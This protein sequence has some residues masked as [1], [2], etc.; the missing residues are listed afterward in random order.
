MV[1]SSSIFLFL[2]LP[3]VLTGYFCLKDNYKNIWL[4]LISLFFYSWG[5]PEY[6]F[7]M[8]LTICLNYTLVLLMVELNKSVYKRFVL[9]MAIISNLFILGYFKYVDFLINI[10][11]DIFVN[12]FSLQQ[13]ALPIGISFFIFQSLSYVID[14]Y[15]GEVK[16][17]KNILYLGLYIA[18]FPQL[19]AGPIVRYK[20]IE[21]EIINR[22]VTI[23][24][25]ATGARQ[26]M[27]GFSKKLLIADSLAPFVNEIFSIDGGSCLVAWLGAVAYTLQIFFDFSGYSDM[28]IGLGRM[29]GFTFPVN[30]YYPYISTS[31][32][33]FWRRWHMSLSSWF[34]DYVYIPL[35]GN[36]NG[37]LRTYINLWI[38][39]FLTGLWHGASWNFVVWGLYHGGFL[40]I[41]RLGADKILEKLPAIFR[42]VYLVV[43]VIIGWVFFN[44]QDLHHAVNYIKTMFNLTGQEY[45]DYIIYMDKQYMTC[46]IAG[47]VFSMPVVEWIRNNSLAHCKVFLLFNDIAVLGM[48]VLAICCMYGAGFS[49]FLYFRF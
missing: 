4:L 24:G 9:Y 23:D 1:F 5:E 25:F 43:I 14:V 39:F 7:L 46:L 28:A 45:V 27:I 21:N 2:F 17:Q 36:R 22:K 42:H 34:K 3:F 31:V 16:A 26:F 37:K 15:R 11:N 32:K 13:V 8:I 33:E 48:F 12:V 30:F 40:V 47:M 19:I 35:G 20:S 49:P 18:L 41:E 29:F 44:A 6:V 10:F 38:V